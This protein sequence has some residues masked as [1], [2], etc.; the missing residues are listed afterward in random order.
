MGNETTVSDFDGLLSFLQRLDRLLE[1]SI[2]AAHQAYGPD[3]A[4]PY[5]GMHVTDADAGQLLTREP[6]APAFL[7]YGDLPTEFPPDLVPPGSRL[8]W[9]QQTFGLSNFDLDV[10]AIALA[11]ELDRRYERLYIYLQD[12]VR[13]KRPTVDLA[14]NLLCA[15]ATTKLTRRT[16]FAAEAPLI[17][18]RLLHLVADANSAKPTLLAHE[19]HLDGAITRFLL[20]QP[21]LDAQL[22]PGCQWISPTSLG[23]FWQTFSPV[24]GSAHPTAAAIASAKRGFSCSETGLSDA[25]APLDARVKSLARLV[26]QAQQTNTPLRLYFYGPDRGEKYCTA[27][28]LA[29]HQQTPL[30]VA[31][32]ARL[33]SSQDSLEPKLRLL[34]RAALLHRAVLFLE[35]LDTLKTPERA[36]AYQTLLTELADFPY[37]A[38]LSGTQAWV[39]SAQQPLGVLSIQFAPPGVEQSVQLWQRH[40]QAVGRS[41]PAE[42][43]RE[44]AGRFRLTAAQI[45]EAVAIAHTSNHWQQIQAGSDDVAKAPHLQDLF[46][47]ARAQLG[48]DL[49]NL[50]RKI[51][52]HY[53]WADIVLPPDT[54][55]QLREICHQVNYRHLVQDTWGF[56]R[57]LSLGSGLAVL[58]AGPPGT[59]KTMAAEVIGH[60][61]QLDLYK[62]DLSQMVSKYIGETEKN[63]N[64]I[65]TAAAAANAILLFDEADALFGKRSEVKDAH[66]RYANIETSYLLQKM[67]EYDGIAILTTNLQSNI[68]EAFLRRLRFVVEFALP[69]AAERLHIWEQ[70]WPDN[71]P[72]SSDLDLNFLAKQLDIPGAAIRNIAL[73][74]AYFA[75]SDGGIVTMAHLVKAIRREYQKM[76]KLLMADEL[77]PYAELLY[78]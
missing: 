65:F 42:Q 62:I 77:E 35:E 36:L 22:I 75:A 12:D 34:V 15:D 28:A 70:I 68:D 41:L 18:Q 61:L 55:A 5:R 44:L 46:A 67:E 64:R 25:I 73:K 39:P 59:G 31:D 6:G 53:T 29:Q 47:A 14:L 60:E 76:G 52:S 71:L 11:P 40:L 23:D 54:K 21:G 20:G 72:H 8:E 57:K 38:I 63:L 4:D 17:R 78:R 37:L 32:L 45:A 50:S 1:C 43:L 10:V 56:G 74:A 7:G 13:G 51:E 49:A 58:F 2:A 19:L 16:H 48:H 27:A 9:L 3:S 30:I 33:V 66:D 26:T 69:Q 24:V